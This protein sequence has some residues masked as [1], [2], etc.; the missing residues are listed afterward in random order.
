M[1]RYKEFTL[2]S[3]A[4]GV[5]GAVILLAAPNP[6]RTLPAD[7]P[8]S[9]E[10]TTTQSVTVVPGD[11]AAA[12]ALTPE[13]GKEADSGRKRLTILFSSNILGETDPCG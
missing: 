9:P 12:D 11:P 2:V 13:P 6:G 5:F 1:N 10:F 8:A 7:I 3:L 4:I